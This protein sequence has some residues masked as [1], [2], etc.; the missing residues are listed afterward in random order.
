LCGL[1]KAAA[2]ADLAKCIYYSRSTIL[3]LDVPHWD[4][5]SLVERHVYISLAEAVVET[6]KPSDP[7]FD[8]AVSMARIEG[9]R[10]LSFPREA[11]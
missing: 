8:L 3:D 6:S 9:C 10:L 5:L 4:A 2:L 7:L 11:D 1:P